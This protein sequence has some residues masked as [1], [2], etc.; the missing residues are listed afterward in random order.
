[1]RKIA[2]NYIFPISGKPIKNGYILLDD[3]GIIQEIGTLEKE[4]E[5]TE[6]YNGILCPG[7][8]NAHC[9]IE[10]SHLK[11][12]F[13]EDTGMSG[14]INQINALRLTVEKEERVAAL[15]SQMEQL[16]AQGV[17]AMGDISNCSES[18]QAKSK[19]PLYTR[20]YLELFGSQ[21]KD[22]CEVLAGGKD[23]A[24][25][26]TEYKLDAA[27]TPHSC[28][29]MSPELLA[30]AAQEGLKSGFLSYHNQ[31][32]TEEE[33]L[34]KSGTGALADNYKGRGLCT[35]PVTGHPALVYFIDRLLTFAKAPVKG[36]IML[37][38][39]VATNEESINYALANLESPYWTICPLSNIFIHRALPPLNLMRKKRLK[40]CLGTDSLSSNK[41]LSMAEEI[42]CIQKNFPD[43]QLEEIITWATLNGAEA[44]GKE[45]ELGSFE[46]GKKPGI[47]L[48]NHIDWQ[49]CK[50]TAGSTTVRL[51]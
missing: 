18:F 46:K 26:A 5:D 49:N 12:Y 1:M 22:A 50:L 10:L 42:K 21:P 45:K 6:F 19:S 31:E 14:F 13:K 39:N 24:N 29:T 16:Y 27:I 41:I 23:L 28:Y 47:V 30:N 38:H 15:E 17:C 25:V 37:V 33:D 36:R 51:A 4:C 35:P 44:L 20:T 7:F 3:N 48:V 8:I 11:G 32:S 40:I 43:I 2:A 34:I 9:H